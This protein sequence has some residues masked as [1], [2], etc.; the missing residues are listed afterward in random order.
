MDFISSNSSLSMLNFL[1][2]IT[3]LQV[4]KRKSLFLGKEI[5]R[6]KCLQLTFKCSGTKMCVCVEKERE[7]VHRRKWGK[8]VNVGVGRGHAGALYHSHNFSVI[9]II[10]R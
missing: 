2:L 7:R 4:W 10:S 9:E 1:T 5:F 8:N 3:I 6:G